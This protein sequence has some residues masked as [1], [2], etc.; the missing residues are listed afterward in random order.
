MNLLFYIVFPIAT[1]IFSIALQKI[2]K[3]PILVAGVIFATFLI[4]A[5]TV[6]T[7]DF[8]IFVILYTI[9]AYITAYLTKLICKI[10]SSGLSNLNVGTINS[11]NIRTN[12]VASNGICCNNVNANTVSARNLVRNNDYGCNNRNYTE[13][14]IR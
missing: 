7:S 1:I 3:C 13:F 2:L 10:S 11:S 14:R 12:S 8:L 5:F 9:I 4:L 6:Y